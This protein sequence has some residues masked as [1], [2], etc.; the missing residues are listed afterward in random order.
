MEI[1]KLAWRKYLTSL[2]KNPLPT[3]ALTA[4][5]LAGC[6]DLVAQKLMGVK[7]LQ[8]RRA[9]LIA[10]YGLLYGGPF[11]H[12]FHKLMDYVFAGKRDQKTVTKKVIVEQLTS[13]PWNNFVFMVYLTSVI[14]GKSWSF[15]K[16]K[17]RND[18]PSVQLNAWRVWPLVGWINYTY[19]PIQFRV[20]FHN[21]AA[22][23][24]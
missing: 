3:K 8:L 4:G 20:L 9:L 5:T 17:L 19:M 7:K 24:W 23:C 14:E 1:V 2:Q 22:V 16:R 21:L 6:S 15:V 10:L 13:G 18:Y 11:G 12:F